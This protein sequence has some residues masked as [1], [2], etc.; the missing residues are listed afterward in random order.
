MEKSFEI[1]WSEPCF[2][3]EDFAVGDGH[4]CHLPLRSE[5]VQGRH[6]I[7]IDRVSAKLYMLL[8]GVIGVCV[9]IG[10]AAALWFQFDAAGTEVL[11]IASLPICAAIGA[12]IGWA[13]WRVLGR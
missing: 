3:A 4:R 5:I 6:S 10:F 2:A 12:G 7:I 8:G 9:A 1:A 13:W 11:V